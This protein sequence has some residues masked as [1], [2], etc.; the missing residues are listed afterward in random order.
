MMTETPDVS[1]VR[2]PDVSHE[3]SDVSVSAVAWFG[4]ALFVLI[5]AVCGLMWAMFGYFEKR[6]RTAEPP[7]ASLI[8]GIEPRTPP[9]PRLQGAPGHEAMPA[10][11]LKKMRDDETNILTSYGWIDQKNGIVRIPIEQ[12]KKI[13]LQKGLPP[14][15][16]SAPAA[17]PAAGAVQGTTR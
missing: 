1:H 15:K 12:A 7:P 14:T 11:D 5:A 2:N 9:E 8:T 13:L 17:T 10:E 16:Q 4:V 3:A 6:E